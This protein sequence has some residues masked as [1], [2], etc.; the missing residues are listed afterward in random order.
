MRTYQDHGDTDRLSSRPDDSLRPDARG[1]AET[2]LKET[3]LAQIRE[4]MAREGAE[5]IRRMA[6][7]ESGPINM[8]F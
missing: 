2:M 8:R 5:P 4:D 1:I 6:K 7:P 3:V